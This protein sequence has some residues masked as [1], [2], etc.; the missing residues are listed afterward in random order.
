MTSNKNLAPSHGSLGSE[1]A[2][3]DIQ[4][5]PTPESEAERMTA[6]FEGHPSGT[7]APTSGGAAGG[8]AAPG[9]DGG[10]GDGDGAGASGS[11]PEVG[12]DGRLF[13][14][15]T[16]YESLWE[17]LRLLEFEYRYNLR[18]D[19]HEL[20]G[21]WLEQRGRPSGGPDGWRPVSQDIE[22]CLMSELA[23]R[24][25]VRRGKSRVPFTLKRETLKQW[26]NSYIVGDLR[27]DPVVQ[28]LDSLPDWDGTERVGRFFQLAYSVVPGDGDGAHSEAYLKAAAWTIFGPLTARAYVPGSVG[29]TA[30][31]L[32]GIG[33]LGKSSSVSWL[34]PEGWRPL[35]FSEGIPVS[36][37]AKAIVELTAGRWLVEFSEMQ[38]ARRA[39]VERIKSVMSSTGDTATLKWQVYGNRYMRRWMGVGTANVSAGGFLP[40]DANNRRFIVVRIP[41]SADPA[42]VRAAVDE[43]REQLWAEAVARVKGRERDP[44]WT[45]MVRE[46]SAEQDEVNDEYRGRATHSE[47]IAARIVDAGEPG[48]LMELVAAAL[49]MRDPAEVAVR[50]PKAVADDVA[51]ELTR[52]G[53]QQRRTR[54]GGVQVRL[55]SPPG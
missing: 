29:D 45:R 12:A 11:A 4:G 40:D 31:V 18:T 53:W 5:G 15:F 13:I 37:T 48:R 41:A 54:V 2:P 27:V 52:H 35:W 51:D 25:R 10:D 17:A 7:G 19:V 33:S 21:Q 49:G 32:A 30:T 38:G 24:F 42:S 28:W 14:P 39:D 50:V 55:W 34:V 36:T 22:D 44:F 1:G 16:G 20:K 43:F 46:V 3:E 23:R 26:L 6:S 9:G 47:D 8:G